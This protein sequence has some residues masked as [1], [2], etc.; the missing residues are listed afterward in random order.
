MSR[1]RVYFKTLDIGGEDYVSEYVEVTQDVLS[2]GDIQIGVDN[3]EFDVGVIRNSNFNV[4]LRN[5]KGKY[6]APGSSNTMF[7]SRV[8]D[9][10]VKITWDARH[11]D[12]HCGF[13][14]VGQEILGGERE[15]FEGVINNANASIDAKLQ[16]ISFTVLGLES[17]LNED[18]IQTPLGIDTGIFSV[19]LRREWTISTMK[20][21]RYASIYLAGY[22]GDVANSISPGF[23]FEP[24]A[25]YLVDA[26]VK[27]QTL[28]SQ[29][30]GMLL[31]A[32]SVMTFEKIK[33]EE[34]GKD[35]TVFI[36]DRSPTADLKYTFKGAGSS[37]GPEDILDVSKYSDGVNRVFNFWSWDDLYSR[38]LGSIETYGHRPKSLSVDAV[39]VSD[40]QE[41]LDTNLAEFK[42]PKIEFEITT[43]IWYSRLNLKILDRV[44]FD[45]PARYLAADNNP[46]PRYGQAVYG[47]ARYPYVIRPITLSSDKHFKILTKKISP[48]KDSMTFRL[49]EV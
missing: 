9:T 30:S 40:R 25:G 37:L 35:Y 13:F 46:I 49:R 8:K 2:I 22:I 4:V 12:L 34:D 32:N 27:N 15:L 42:D 39:T 5:D 47:A 19:M 17:Y 36:K 45:F 43:P 31:A 20:T 3:T 6:S 26:A 1:F 11:H 24:D 33:L 44:N 23:D 10:F 28:G 21:A 7:R 48:S 18:L 38:D 16:T 29:M 41:V 14:K